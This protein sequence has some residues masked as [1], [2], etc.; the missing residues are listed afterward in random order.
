VDADVQ[1]IVDSATGMFQSDFSAR[2]EPF[3]EVVKQVKSTS[4]GTIVEL[5]LESASGDEAQVLVTTSVKT[6]MPNQPDA[7]PQS[8]RMRISLNKIDA[9]NIKISDVTFVS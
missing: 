1:R 3:I 2:S 9:E 4:V 6:T 8:W 7:E 5:A